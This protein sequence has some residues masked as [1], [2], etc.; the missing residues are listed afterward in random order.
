MNLR[1]IILFLAFIT[2][3]TFHNCLLNDFIGDDRALF[4]D[5]LF[6]KDLK[7]LPRLFQ[8]DFV[9]HPSRLDVTGPA[10]FSGCISY[11]PVTALTFF[12]DYALWG[13]IPFGHHLTNILLHFFAVILVFYFVLRLTGK[14]GFSFLTALLFA[15]HP[16]Q[17]EVVNTIGYRSDV[18]LVLFYL[19]SLI[20]Y[21]QY[22]SHEGRRW[23]LLLVSLCG[24]FLA[25]FS[26]ETAVTLLVI[27]VAMDQLLLPQSPGKFFKKSYLAFVGITAFYLYV[28]FVA[29]PTVY[30]PKFPDLGYG[31]LAKLVLVLTIFAGYLKVL[32][33]PF[34]VTILPP[35][36]APPIEPVN[37]M[38]LAF[39]L[40]GIA[41][42]SFA[43]VYF[44][45]RKKLVTFAVIWF[46]VTYLPVSYV[47][48]L[49]NPY[50]FR[51]LYL[52]SVGFIIL[53]ALLVQSAS[54][55]LQRQSD[56]LQAGRVFQIAVV[57]LCMAAT[58]ANNSFFK[59]DF[60]ACHEM[61]RRYPE[62]SRPYW[63]LGLRYYDAGNYPE[64]VKYLK[65][66]LEAAINNP[67]ISREKTE[68]V[69]HHLIG[70][71]YV[72]DTDQAIAHLQKA[73]TLMP[74]LALPYLDLSRNYIVK[75]DYPLAIRYAEESLK[76]D[77]KLGI[78]YVYIIHSNVELNRLDQ[79]RAVLIR[80]QAIFPGDPNLKIVEDYLRQKEAGS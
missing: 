61:V 72:Y 5:N 48:P 70:R 21:Y 67:F 25:L 31:P 68:F 50:A 49:L 78:A 6:Y 33:L 26:K 64:A 28:Y 16:V 3:I 52:P 38:T 62:S 39:A 27:L 2:L 73:A 58:I 41:T 66:H 71:A 11:R 65:K 20:A 24:Y 14:E 32:L 46:V 19:L 35:M 18:L 40:W 29:M 69:T 34:T 55:R 22:R 45:P 75:K 74:E 17:S 53:L 56:A 7:N 8:K 30:Y 76:R 47:V 1:R 51:F 12:I 54:V 80:A 57:G 44:Y 77:K 10:S 36:Y 79:A 43:A 60:V 15:V 4:T 42:L 13:R 23:P 63:V 59:N 9:M 37:P